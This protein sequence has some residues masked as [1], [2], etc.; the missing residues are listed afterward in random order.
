MKL[1]MLV[2]A[3]GSLAMPA[4]LSAQVDTTKKTTD[5]ATKMTMDTSM[6][7]GGDTAM[8]MRT[9]TTPRTR[10]RTRAEAR[11]EARERAKA[12]Q[13]AG[14]EAAVSPVTGQPSAAAAHDTITREAG[15]GPQTTGCP[16]GCPTSKGAAGL[17]GVQFLALQQEL[18]DRNCGNN[19]VTGVLDA[20][21]RRAISNCAK[22]YGVANSA[23]AVLAAMNIGFTAEELGAS[24][25]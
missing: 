14:G 22:R 6:K 20:P 24:K 7:M 10:A 2:V 13:T 8:K 3:V 9:R 4:I 25:S 1:S 11:E 15:A 21:T 17:T 19:H 16:L 23:A 18:R 12:R 5:T